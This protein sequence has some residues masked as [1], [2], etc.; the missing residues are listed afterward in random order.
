MT[1]SPRVVVRGEAVT[2]VPPDTADLVVTRAGPRPASRPR[3]RPARRA[4]AG[5]DRSARGAPRRRSARSPPTPSRCTPSPRTA[6]RSAGSVASITTRVPVLDVGA[7]GELAV[8]VAALP[9]TSLHG[10][11]WRLSRGH[12][13][14]QQVRTEAV[15]DAVDRATPTP[16]R[17]AAGSPGSWRCATPAPASARCGRWRSPSTRRT[18]ARPA[19]GAP[20][21]ARLGRGHLHHVRTRPGGLRA[22]RFRESGRLD[23]SSVQD[24]RGGGGGGGRGLAVGG[25][26]LGIVGVIVVVLFQVLG[27]GGGDGTAG[28][29]GTFG[30]LGSGQTADNTELEQSCRTGADANDSVECAVVAEID[31]IQD[32][33]GQPGVGLPAGGHRLLQR[34]GAD[35]LRWG[36][37]RSGPSTARPTSSSTSTSTFFDD[38]RTPVRRGGRHLRQRRTCSPTST[39]T[40]CRTCWAPTSR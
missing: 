28:L 18:P 6:R 19:A 39:A 13:A 23:T 2:E 20:G 14:H 21:G 37:Q 32:Y 3:P 34:P 27:G 36:D 8:A 22:M 24:R 4:A 10:P 7:A 30:Q 9:D 17:W 16:R 29:A 38:L 26:G 35:R 12:P 11:Q 31:S 33:W 5:A 1:E 25:G 40:T 15:A